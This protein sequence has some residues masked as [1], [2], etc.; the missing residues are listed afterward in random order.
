MSVDLFVLY[1]QFQDNIRILLLLDTDPSQ[2]VKMGYTGNSTSTLIPSW[3][4]D[5]KSAIYVGKLA[6]VIA[7]TGSLQ[8]N[9]SELL[10]HSVCGNQMRN[11]G[12]RLHQNN[13]GD[14]DQS[15]SQL[16]TGQFIL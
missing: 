14:G 5:Q 15:Q 16:Q 3:P 10:P 6:V 4:T 11:Q 12:G 9:R 8:W 13:I 2:N 7:T 1:S